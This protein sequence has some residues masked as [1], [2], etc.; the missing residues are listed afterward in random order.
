MQGLSS[1]KNVLFFAKH[2][3]AKKVI[4]QDA[5]TMKEQ[6]D[7]IIHFYN[8]HAIKITGNIL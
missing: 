8:A 5:Q 7:L 3:Q 6:G 4:V 2:V 1:V